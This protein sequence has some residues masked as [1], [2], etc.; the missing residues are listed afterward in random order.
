M[1]DASTDT[2]VTSLAVWIVDTDTDINSNNSS[3]NDDG[4]DDGID[5][6]TRFDI[7]ILNRIVIF[8]STCNILLLKYES[9]LGTNLI[10]F[11][12]TKLSTEHMFGNGTDDQDKIGR[13]SDTRHTRVRERAAPTQSMKTTISHVRCSFFALFSSCLLCQLS[14]SF[15]FHPEPC[16]G[17]FRFY[18]SAVQLITLP[19]F[20][21]HR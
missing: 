12:E 5:N 9:N 18:E 3:N 19:S 17:S 20:D 2:I 13:E 4:N 6:H 7:V 14:P 16:W 15:S 10:W 11:V 8:L 1:W 21:C